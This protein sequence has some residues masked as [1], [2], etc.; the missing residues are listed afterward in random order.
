MKLQEKE[1]K[2]LCENK[3]YENVGLTGQLPSKTGPKV[4]HVRIVNRDRKKKCDLR[5]YCD[6]SE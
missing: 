5:E 1:R 6:G 3:R 4:E 2:A